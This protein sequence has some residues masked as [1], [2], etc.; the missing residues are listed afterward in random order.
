MPK[1]LWKEINATDFNGMTGE[2]AI[3]GTGGGARHIVLGISKAGNDVA[4][5]LPAGHGNEVEIDT[6]AGP[7]WPISKLTF[8][9]NPKRRSGEWLIADQKN[10]RHPAWKVAAGFPTTFDAANP[11]FVMVFEIDDAYHVA[12]LDKQSLATLAPQI[13][14]SERGVAPV[15]LGLLAKLGLGQKSALQEFVDTEPTTSTPQ[16]DPADQKDARKRIVAEVVRRQGQRSF[17]NSL[18]KAYGIRCAVTG[19]SVSWVLQAAHIS[20]YQGPHTNKPDNGLLLR[21]DIHTL[22]DLGLLSVN[23]TTLVIRV[24]KQITEPE[25][26]AFDGQKLFV[27]NIAPSAAALKEH[28]VRST[29]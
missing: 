18:M 4:A 29:A 14:K 23:P 22:F 20:P 19:C 25:Y 28:W 27:G 2:A 6:A 3:S 24:A 21:A 26:R 17:R 16:F 11:P 7:H 15:P 1:V 8:K 5:F 13:V 12:W 9:S 10:H